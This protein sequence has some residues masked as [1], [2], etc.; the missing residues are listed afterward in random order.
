M[1]PDKDIQA[2]EE[3]ETSGGESGEAEPVKDLS[4]L[5]L[6]FNLGD[7]KLE[8]G[9]LRNGTV[10]FNLAAEGKLPIP[11]KPPLVVSLDNVDSIEETLRE[12]LGEWITPEKRFTIILPQEWGQIIEIPN[13]GIT[14]E[15]ELSQHVRW[16]M[17]MNSW[18]DK[19]PLHFNFQVINDDRI[20]VAAVRDRVLNFAMSLAD[21]LSVR[22]IQLSLADTSFINLIS[23][24]IST[25]SDSAVLDRA[26]PAAEPVDKIERPEPETVDSGEESTSPSAQPPEKEELTLPEP[27]TVVDDYEAD[28]E[29]TEKG[30]RKSVLWFIIPLIVVG[31]G[32]VGY[33]KF[34][35]FKDR[36]RPETLST[37]E[38]V[39]STLIPGESPAVIEEPSTEAAESSQI[40]SASLVQTPLSGLAN[41]LHEHSYINSLSIT[42]DFIKCKAEFNSPGELENLL[43]IINNTGVTFS[44]RRLHG[45]HTADKYTAI[46]SFRIDESIVE[47]YQHPLAEDIMTLFR[48]SGF[49]LNDGVFTGSFDEISRFLLLLDR[50]KILFY[51]LVLAERHADYHLSLE[52]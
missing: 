52:Y 44:A 16:A 27:E 50:Q 24:E 11:F 3:V 7:F 23:A 13:P 47:T 26:V 19:E 41:I 1:H 29:E 38:E 14:A 37:L 43:N 2:P 34:G 31:V 51:R 15:D 48:D 39:D 25:D 21:R 36:I 9:D 42:A 28:F 18:E 30:G 10:Y 46:F 6:V 17:R 20:V 22:L 4:L 32:V 49:R 5:R 8:K 40:A 45:E 33:L 35:V 12:S